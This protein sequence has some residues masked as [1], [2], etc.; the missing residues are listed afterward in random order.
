MLIE[1]KEII[2]K[3]KL[4]RECHSIVTEIKE[5]TTRCGTPINHSENRWV[6]RSLRIAETDRDREQIEERR[7]REGGQIRE[8]ERGE[9][10]RE[11]EREREERERE[12]RERE[13]ERER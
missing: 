3:R 10:E 7:Q 4:N 12:E 9:R 1:L 2:F 11:R 13:R 5:K 8:R 6:F